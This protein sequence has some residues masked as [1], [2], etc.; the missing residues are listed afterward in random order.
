MSAYPKAVYDSHG[1]VFGMPVRAGI[2][3]RLVDVSRGAAGSRFGSCAGQG[4]VAHRGLGRV[5]W[6]LASAQAGRVAIIA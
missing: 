3:W 4:A 6:E 1:G 5:V 2:R